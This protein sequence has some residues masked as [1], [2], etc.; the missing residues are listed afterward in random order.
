MTSSRRPIDD[1]S[2]GMR[3]AA[4]WS[5]C[6]LAIAAAA[7]V[8]AWLLAQVGLVTVTLAVGIMLTALLQPLVAGLHRRGVPRGLAAVGVFVLGILVFIALVWFVVDQITA[9][10]TSMS[11]RLYDAAD[12]IQHWLVTGPLQLDPADAS[13]YTTDL[14]DTISSNTD[15]IRE[16]LESTASSALGIVSGAVLCLF[17]TLFLMLDDGRIWRWVLGLFPRRVRAQVHRGGAAAWRTLTVYMRS[18]VLL[19]ALN[20][21]TMVPVMLLAGMPLVVPLAVLLFLGSLVPMI[22][23]IVAGVI[24]ALIALVTQ[25]VTT[26]V[27]VTIALVVIVQLFGNLLNPIILGKFVN[28]HPLAILVT[29]TAG[30]LVAGIFGAFVAVPIVAVINNAVKVMRHPPADRPAPRDEPVSETTA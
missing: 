28:I 10:Q 2:H 29:V 3:V 21:L 6:F 15:M 1:V 8:L 19:A 5:L 7:L 14:D 9:A 20:A 13:R 24:V 12:S 26:A 30:T 23:V 18:L 25:G 22:G 16:R 4:W 11:G 27:V 17:A